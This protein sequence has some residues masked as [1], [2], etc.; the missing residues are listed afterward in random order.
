MYKKPLLFIILAC[1]HLLEP[2]IKV[3]YFKATTSF[4]FGT[5]ISNIA[6]IQTTREIFDFWFLF[7]I[8]GLALI[9][10]KK[11]SYPIFV[12]VQAYSIYAH[13]TYEKYT[14]PY[15]SEV[16]FASSLALLFMNVLIIAYFALPDVRRIFFDKSMRWWETRKRYAIRIPVSFHLDGLRQT[17][18]C[19]LLN[20]SQTGAFIN[21]NLDLEQDANIIM[22]ISYKRLKIKVRCIVKSRHSFQDE[23]GLGIKFKFSN[24]WE[25]LHIRKI[26]KEIS[27]DVKEYEKKKRQLPNEEQAA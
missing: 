7:P 23:Q 9:S 4:S 19:H 17:F 25:N 2:L 20:I 13:L 18:N 22:T 1:A 16:P 21:S 11:W 8:G 12:S 26:V 14:W 24:I 15:I 27:N 3:I 10:V 5:V 6:Q